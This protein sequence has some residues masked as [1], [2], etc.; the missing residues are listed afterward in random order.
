MRRTVKITSDIDPLFGTLDENLK[1]FEAV[2][3]VTTHLRDDGLELEGD[4]ERVERAEA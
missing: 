4:P 1:R 2:L 3:Q